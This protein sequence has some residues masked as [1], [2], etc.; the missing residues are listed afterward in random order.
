VR[1]FL[2]NLL[3]PFL[4]VLVFLR[5]TIWQKRVKNK[6]YSNQLFK[7]IDVALLSN[8][9]K[10]SPYKISKDFLRAR[11]ENNIFTYGSTPLHVYHEILTRWIKDHSGCFLELGSG[12]GRGLLFMRCFSFCKVSG[13]EWNPI[14]NEIL[15]RILKQFNITNIDI[16][17]QDYKA[18]G[19]FD[20]DWMYFYEFFL[21]EKELCNMCDNFSKS[22]IKNFK[23]ITVSF[24]LSDYHRDFV[25]LD[26]FNTWFPWGRAE[27]FLNIFKKA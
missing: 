20:C 22:P 19:A 7:K 21:S 23:I 1:V 6:F 15:K 8:Y 13:V 5:E 3:L 26:H 11:N 25:T 17:N 9:D 27:V 4:S 16:L 10:L 24:P 18:V 2:E 12:T 14:F